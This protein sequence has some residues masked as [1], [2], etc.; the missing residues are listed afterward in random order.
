MRSNGPQREDALGPTS[1]RRLASQWSNERDALSAK[2]DCPTRRAP[3]KAKPCYQWLCALT[4][5]PPGAR[6]PAVCSRRPPTLHAVRSTRGAH[7]MWISFQQQE[8][9]HGWTIQRLKPTLFYWNICRIS[10]F[11]STYESIPLGIFDNSKTISLIKISVL[12][13]KWIKDNTHL[14]RFIYIA[15]LYMIKKR[16]ICGRRHI[17]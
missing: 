11:I 3:P 12:L 17:C 14:E 4:M 13:K 15:F 16:V 10:I 1:E 8:Q 5:P 6:R 9:K 2:P 7:V